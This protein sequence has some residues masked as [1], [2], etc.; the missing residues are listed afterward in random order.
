[1][2]K[3][4]KTKHLNRTI[5]ELKYLNDA[6]EWIGFVNLN[7][8]IQELKYRRFVTSISYTTDLNRTTQELK[9]S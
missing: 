2:L 3:S 9:C 6:I 4:R 5:Q 1:M 7:R 8:T